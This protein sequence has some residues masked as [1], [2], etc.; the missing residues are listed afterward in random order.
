MAFSAQL[1]ARGQL[2]GWWEPGRRR[3]A[4]FSMI[5]LAGPPGS[6]ICEGFPAT[7]GSD[8]PPGS[9]FARRLGAIMEKRRSPG[10]SPRGRGINLRGRA[11]WA[12][13]RISVTRQ[14]YT[15][16]VTKRLIDIDDDLLF[17]AKAALGADT[18][19]ETVRAALEQVVATAAHAG[20]PTS[21]LLADFA[22]ATADLA[23]PDVMDA[24]W[25]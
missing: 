6:R 15:R 13:A 14:I 22:S 4:R 10:R 8:A 19:K 16:V 20:T 17:A 1:L 2:C 25:R 21:D 5:V 3:S 7:G 9:R 12:R 18:L 11:A 24:A 23:D